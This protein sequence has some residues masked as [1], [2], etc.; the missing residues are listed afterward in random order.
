MKTD[1]SENPEI[2]EGEGRAALEA[3]RAGKRIKNKSTLLTFPEPRPNTHAHHWRTIVC[4]TDSQGDE[5]DVCECSRC[6]EQQE[7]G[8]TFDEEYA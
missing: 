7:F 6:G 2:F 8:C 3:H 4:T 1:Q 5:R